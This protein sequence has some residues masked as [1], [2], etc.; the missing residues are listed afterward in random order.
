MSQ[1]KGLVLLSRFD[2]LDYKKG[3]NT[4]KE[5][6]KKISTPETNFVRQP[7]IGANLY[8][9]NILVIVDE[10]LLKEYFDG[11]IEEFR[12]MGEWTAHGII[13]RYFNIYLEEQKPIDFLA[14]FA[15]LR[16]VLVGSGD[17]IITVQ[18]AKSVDVTIDYGQPIPRSICLSEQGFI[19]EGLK[20]CGAKEVDVKEIASASDGQSLA[21]IYHISF[22]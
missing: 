17:M 11:D 1:I 6:L 22:K 18:G 2:Y 21:S 9:E 5:F 8:P 13:S 10:V 4:V 15:R 3:L 7:V 19:A 16:D 12:R 20:M 14:Q